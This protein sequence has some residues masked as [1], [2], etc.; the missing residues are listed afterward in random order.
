[1]NNLM[2]KYFQEEERREKANSDFIRNSFLNSEFS[3]LVYGGVDIQD[4]KDFLYLDENDLPYPNTSFD[5]GSDGAFDYVD[6]DGIVRLPFSKLPSSCGGSGS[7]RPDSKMVS[8][9]GRHIN[10]SFYHDG[11]PCTVTMMD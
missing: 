7:N 5:N 11:S 6:E 3:E 10:I 4:L 8:H 2:P 9:M 1:M